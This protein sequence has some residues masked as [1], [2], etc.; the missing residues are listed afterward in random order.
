MMSVLVVKI[1]FFLI[2]HCNLL[3]FLLTSC[4]VRYAGMRRRL[5]VDPHIPKDGSNSPNLVMD[6]PLSL[7]PGKLSCLF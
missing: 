2:F 7:N 3:N 5:L 6:N 1:G 4:L